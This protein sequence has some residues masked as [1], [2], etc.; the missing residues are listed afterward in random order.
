MGHVPTMLGQ[1]QTDNCGLEVFI[2][3]EES[4]S[5]QIQGQKKPMTATDVTGFDAIFLHWI[6]RYFLQILGGS[7]Y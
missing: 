2:K 6:F 3:T 1:S 4:H 5:L 7:S